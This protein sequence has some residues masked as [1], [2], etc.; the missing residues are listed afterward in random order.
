ML[1]PAECL[2]DITRRRPAPPRIIVRILLGGHLRPHLLQRSA[3][4]G[5]LADCS[6]AGTADPCRLRAKKRRKQRRLSLFPPMIFTRRPTRHE[7]HQGNIA[8][9]GPASQ[10]SP[11][12]RC[13]H[14]QPCLG[15]AS[16]APSCSVRC[17]FS[18]RGPFGQVIADDDVG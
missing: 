13:N 4:V 7:A 12:P 15:L 10:P 18:Y 9:S 3:R 11:S 6:I 2:M 1:H 17:D 5:S 8:S 14:T 16:A